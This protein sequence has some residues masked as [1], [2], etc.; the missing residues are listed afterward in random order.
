MGNVWLADKGIKQLQKSPALTRLLFRED[1]SDAICLGLL[2]ALGS[3]LVPESVLTLF[4]QNVQQYL[5]VCGVMFRNNTTVLMGD[6]FSPGVQRISVDLMAGEH[7]TGRLTLELSES[8]TLIQKRLLNQVCQM[9]AFPMK[10][11]LEHQTVQ[12]MALMD[13]LTGLSNRNA[14]EI[15]LQSAMN[16]CYLNRDVF[17][18]L[19][20]DIDDFQLINTNQGHQ[21]GDLV[22]SCFAELLRSCCQDKAQAFRFSGDKFTVLV[23]GNDPH[24][25][26]YL[27]SRVRQAVASHRSLAEYHVS[28]RTGYTCYERGDSLYSLFERAE[29]TLLSARDNGKGCLTE[30]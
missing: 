15:E 1:S 3:S 29:R 9:V 24:F 5:P 19:I 2:Q 23:R 30:G 28:C 20:L 8:V 4:S 22:L 18:I 7:L 27:A 14:F 21:V 11:A 6:N 16:E 10:N 17:S 13:S 25:P 12:Q 26:G